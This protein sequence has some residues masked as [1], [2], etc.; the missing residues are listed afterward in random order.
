MRKTFDAEA[1]V[2]HMAGVMGIEIRAEWR[3]S[4]VANVT[5]TEAIARAVLSFPLTDHDEPA[6]VFEP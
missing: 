3:D 4:V 2:D 6:P 5:A 1:H